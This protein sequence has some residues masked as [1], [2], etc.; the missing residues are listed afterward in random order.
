M[1]TAMTEVVEVRR[2]AAT[3]ARAYRVESLDLLR[4]LVIVL[5]ALD[6]VRDFMMVAATTDPMTD[7][8]VAPSLFFTRW[9]T[10]FCAPVFVC[11]AGVSAGLMTARRRPRALGAFL[12][13]RGLWLIVVEM[14]VVSS[15]VTFAPLG[16][17]EFGGRTVVVMQVIWAIGASMLVLAAAQFLGQRACL[18]IG[19]MIL[20]GHNLLDAVWPA[21]GGP[22][23]VG[24]PLWV[25]LHAQ[26]AFAAGPFMFGFVYPVVPWVGVMLLGFGIAPVWQQI[27]S[28]RDAKLLR[29]GLGA[30]AAF[31]VLRVV[32]VYG[33]PNSWQQQ[34]S[35]VATLLDFL[36]VTKYPPSL[37]FLLMTL[38]PAAVFSVCADRIPRSVGRVLITFGRV[39]FAFYVA[40]VFVIHL[41]AM[42]L[43]MA[44]GF[45]AGQF[46]TI[47]FLYPKGYGVGLGSIY[48]LW[49]LIVLFLYPWCRWMASVK[50]RRRDWWLSY[51]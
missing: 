28:I 9:I 7:P 5:M 16:I 51:V 36:N 13:R 50:E 40:H 4:G 38:G 12:A 23:E 18:A 25:S 19:A 24:P 47:F 2:P 43:G 6:H 49:L 3:N 35:G 14:L 29:Y 15:A 42:A 34:A 37:A 33:D 41:V 20:I 27:P 22:F 39:P 44:Q 45:R 8:N 1:S 17:P 48:V 46:L 21:T 26:M 10:H 30:I 11:L 31:I 32:E